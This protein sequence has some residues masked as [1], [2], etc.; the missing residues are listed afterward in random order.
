V[1]EIT[2]LIEWMLEGNQVEDKKGNKWILRSLD[3]ADADTNKDSSRELTIN[4]I[5]EELR[6]YKTPQQLYI[7]ELEAKVEAYEQARR[8]KENRRRRSNLGPGEV[9]DVE[10]AIRKGAENRWIMN[11]YNI[12][13]STLN[14]IKH[15][16]HKYSTN[17][18]V[19]IEVER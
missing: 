5:S 18:N 14:R 1:E 13:H 10:E 16:I 2:K 6:I 3:L 17:K 4:R 12:A 15:G 7:E 9:K 8:I 19:K 11:T